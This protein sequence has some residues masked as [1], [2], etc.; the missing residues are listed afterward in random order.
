MIDESWAKA[1]AQDWIEAWNTHDLERVM[2]HYT[3]DFEMSSPL[4]IERMGEPSGML[5]GKANIRPYWEKG[6]ATQPPLR[7]ELLQVLV[8]VD[9]VTIFYRSVARRIAAEVLIFNPG[10][11]VVRGIAHYGAPA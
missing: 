1:F 5:R 3:D 10:R 8:G 9:S 11:E 4:I 2:S 6:L 7:F